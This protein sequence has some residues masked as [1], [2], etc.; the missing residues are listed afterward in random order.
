MYQFFPYIIFSFFS[1]AMLVFLAVYGLQYRHNLGVKEFIL[2]MLASAWWVFCQA[3]E[4]MALTLQ[5]K[6]FWAT[7]EYIG[8]LSVFF[9]LMLAMRF[10]GYGRYLTKRN[11]TAVLLVYAVFWLLFFTDPWHGLMRANFALDAS[12]LPYTIQKD[13][14][15]LYPLYVLFCYALNI[16]TFAFLLVTARRKDSLYRKQALFLLVFLLIILIPNL[17]Y[18]LRVS[19]VTRFDL[20]PAFFGFA[21]LFLA[22]GIF[23]HKFLNIMPIARD[24]LIERMDSGILVADSSDRIIDVNRAA[25][26]MFQLA[27][28]GILGRNIAEIPLLVSNL[29]PEGTEQPKHFPYQKAGR[30]F[31]YEIKAHPIRG[32][33][34]ER[35]GLLILIADVTENQHNLQKVIQQQKAL[36]VMQ[37]RERLG[38]ELH[39]G[40]GQV[41]GYINAQAQ[42]VEEYL[43]R[44]K[45][46]EAV[47]QLQE[48]IRVSRDAHSDIRNYILEMRGISSRNRSFSAV[49]KQYAAEFSENTAIPVKIFFDDNLSPNF[50]REAQAVNLLKIIQESLNNIRKHAGASRA[51]IAFEQKDHGVAVTV[52]D[53]GSGFDP[54]EPREGHHYGLTIMQERA[55]E[56]GAELQISSPRGAG[57]QIMLTL[58]QGECQ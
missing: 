11:I 24:L 18:Y 1:F 2:A 4:L 32:D 51:Q 31:I 48:L 19:P 14:G 53:N 38:R 9:Y 12:A 6:L 57:T 39:D 13:Y 15:M 44:Q 7:I 16:A 20:T 40:L 26:A 42:T 49:L 45:E 17:T 50:P 47:R 30:E 54:A 35:L 27:K 52:S 22:Y 43:T 37:E 33:R 28:A 25:L 21:A 55:R 58:P 10:A 41:F 23:Q 34:G 36:G 8:L 3:F 5:V 46:Q 56:M 29:P